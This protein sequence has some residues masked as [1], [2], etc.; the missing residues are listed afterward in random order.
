MPP[1][2]PVVPAVVTPPEPGEVVV[3]WAPP[4]ASAAVVAM[5]DPVELDRLAAFARPADRDRYATGCW[6]V[7]TLV[8]RSLG[9]APAAVAVDRTCR[10]CGAGHGRP[11]VT[12]PLAVSVTHAG[13][14]VGVAVAH[15]APP[16]VVGPSDD[17][18]GVGLDVS[19]PD[20]RAALAEVA[21][22]F[23]APSER[24]WA[25]SAEDRARLWVAKEAVLKAAGVGLRVD[26]ATVEMAPVGPAAGSGSGALRLAAWPLPVAPTEVHLVALSP[27]AG[28]TGALAWVGREGPRVREHLIPGP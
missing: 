23:L 22:T 28:H 27:G 5:L 17:G 26:P 9:S 15:G 24:T 2:S 11:R 8:G 6:L 7:R 20:E 10:S 16:V 25:T 18:S 1:T 13:D 4:G 21:T 12:A 14:R 3:V 19:A